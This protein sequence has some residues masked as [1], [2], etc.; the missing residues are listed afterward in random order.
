M[1]DWNPMEDTL[2]QLN[3]GLNGVNTGTP[4]NQIGRS[5]RPE[6]PQSMPYSP[7]RNEST[8]S[9]SSDTYTGPINQER[10]IS[11]EE[12][13][14]QEKEKI[15]EKT[16][17]DKIWKERQ[18][19]IRAYEEERQQ[20]RQEAWA[21]W[22]KKSFGQKVLHFIGYFDPGQIGLCINRK[23]KNSVEEYEKRKVK[24][25]YSKPHLEY[26]LKKMHMVFVPVNKITEK[27]IGPRHLL[28]LS[29]VFAIIAFQLL[30]HQ[31]DNDYF[32]IAASAIALYS[33]NIFKVFTVWCTLL[34]FNCVYYLGVLWENFVKWFKG[35]LVQVFWG[36]VTI[37][38]LFTIVGGGFICIQLFRSLS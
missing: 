20:K 5:M 25:I 22:K 7:P 10:E 1:A 14:R 38:I 17:L 12:K 24:E 29:L 2:Y 27:L 23:I 31:T 9:Y 4:A 26:G 6:I 11:A 36:T 37:M 16:R 15:R 33:L 18:A 28:V 35:F 8:S 32:A 21:Q 19:K 34:F 13:A 30:S 3:A